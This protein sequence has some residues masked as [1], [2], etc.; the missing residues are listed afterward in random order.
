M[1]GKGKQEERRGRNGRVGK[2]REGA[3]DGTNRRVSWSTPSIV[4][5]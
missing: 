3:G 4:F 1:G 2:M 5:S